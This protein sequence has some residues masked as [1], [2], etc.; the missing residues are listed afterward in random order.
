MTRSRLADL[1]QQAF[2]LL[3]A[4]PFLVLFIGLRV[5]GRAHLPARGPF[6]MV[7]NHQSHLD[8]LSLLALFPLSFLRELRP[9]AAADYFARSRW[10]ALLTGTLFNV[11]PIARR[12]ADRDQDGD[13]IEAMAAAV[14]AGHSLLLFPEGTRRSNAEDIGQ[15][16]AGVS[17]LLDRH[18]Q[19]PVV[20]CYLVNMG[21]SLPK[22]ALVPVPF[23]CEVRIGP[24]RTFSGSREE[25][26][27]ALQDAVRA[28]EDLEE[29]E[30]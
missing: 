10:V 27:A 23:F 19:L 14:E 26:L 18:P 4:R 13:P 8:T 6:L 28:L 7:A 1:V 9:V 15:F 17:H 30:P 22:G 20:P 16:K 5:R 12:S 2:F 3:F 21:R 29:D 25:V 24:P 11:L